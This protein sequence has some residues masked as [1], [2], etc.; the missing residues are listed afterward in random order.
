MLRIM[1]PEERADYY[2]LLS[3]EE[4]AR[5]DQNYLNALSPEERFQVMELRRAKEKAEQLEAEV[6][7]PAP[8]P[9]TPTRV[10]GNGR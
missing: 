9:W 10:C 2:A 4:R 3:P 5:A 7:H 8:G 6:T 1:T